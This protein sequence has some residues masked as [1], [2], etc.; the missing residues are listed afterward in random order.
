MLKLILIMQ[1]LRDG[2]NRKRWIFLRGL[3]R[4][5]IHWGNFPELFKNANPD[6]EV[7][8]LEIPGNGFLNNEIT[9]TNIIQVIDLLKSKS[10]FCKE[11]VP[12]NIC[13]ISLGGMIALKMGRALSSTN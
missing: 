2:M 9:P 13:G 10:N 11:N 7:E 3:T 12:I 6:N 5:N 1:A 8:F 4:G